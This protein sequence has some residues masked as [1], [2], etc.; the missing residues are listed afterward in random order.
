ML[1]YITHFLWGGVINQIPNLVVLHSC[2]KIQ[3]LHLACWKGK[4]LQV[5]DTWSSVENSLSIKNKCGFL[6]D[7]R[8][9]TFSY[10]VGCLYWVNGLGGAWE[11]ETL[12]TGLSCKTVKNSFVRSS[13][14][15]FI[16]L[17]YLACTL[18]FLCLYFYFR[19]AHKKP[20]YTMLLPVLV[21]LL[22]SPRAFIY[23]F[24]FLFFFICRFLINSYIY[25]NSVS[26]IPFS[27]VFSVSVRYISLVF[28]PTLL[29][30]LFIVFQAE[31]IR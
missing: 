20:F 21:V 28:I 27:V 18:S 10:C 16:A 3:S 19:N 4:Y 31:K 30:S 15:S 1:L 29:P 23:F 7:F 11:E 25:F 17:Q 5:P 13:L 14:C 2:A 8:I 26:S 24:F 12:N 6:E 9:C 22:A